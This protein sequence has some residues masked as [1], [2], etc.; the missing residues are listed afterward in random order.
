MIFKKKQMLLAVADGEVISLS[1]V[2]DE[3]F[4]SGMLGVGFAIEPSMGTVSSPVGGIVE[5]V[6]ETGHAYTIHTKDGLDILVHIGIDTVSL[7]GDGFLP[8]VKEGDT[9]KAG[10]VLARV[11]LDRVRKSG[12][13]VTVPVLITNPEMLRDHSCFVGKHV[14]GGKDAVMEYRTL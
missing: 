1:S 12:C 8:M 5:S 9:V 6:A 11:D 4:A 13:P 14:I 2:R 3:A 7:N 10:D